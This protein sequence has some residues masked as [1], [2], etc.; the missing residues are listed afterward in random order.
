MD[1]W[2]KLKNQANLSWQQ[3]SQ[4]SQSVWQAA[5]LQN[6]KQ[7][8]FGAVRESYHWVARTRIYRVGR[9]GIL[10]AAVSRLGYVYGTGYEKDILVA[11]SFNRLREKRNG[12]ENEYLIADEN[13]RLYQVVSSFWYWQWFP[14]ELWS[15]LK[16]GQRY[17]VKGYG[18]RIR[19][20]GIHPRLVKAKKI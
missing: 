19:R 12:V 9:W 18:V 5:N 16:E 7:V 3:A 8:S 1:Y 14:D 13:H 17:H 6:L 15:S 20:L 4:I 10:A 11:K 2:Y